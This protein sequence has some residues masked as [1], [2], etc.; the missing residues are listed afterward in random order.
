MYGL[1]YKT[2]VH[3]VYVVLHATKQN[4]TRACNN[5]VVSSNVKGA[6]IQ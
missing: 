3:D 5:R 6:Y 2:N 4:K 1:N